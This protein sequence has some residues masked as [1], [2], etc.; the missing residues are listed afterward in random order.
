M[1]QITRTVAFE[2]LSEDGIV[3]KL[4]RF[5]SFG[6]LISVVKIPN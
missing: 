5:I 3:R 1:Q 6:T 4:S 2:I